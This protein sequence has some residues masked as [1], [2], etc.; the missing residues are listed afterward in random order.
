V[1]PAQNLRVVAF[2]SD[3]PQEWEDSYGNTNLQYDVQVVDE[4]GEIHDA[5][6]SKRASAD[7]PQVNEVVSAKLEDVSGGQFPPKL[8]TV[9]QDGG[10][11]RSGGQRRQSSGGQQRRGAQSSGKGGN[12]GA[13]V[14]M[15]LNAGREHVKAAVEIA[16]ARR[17]AGEQVQVPDFSYQAVVKAAGWYFDVAGHIEKEGE[18]YFAQR[19]QAAQPPPQQ[20]LGAQQPDMSPAP[21]SAE[22]ELAPD[23]TGLG[24]TAAPPADDEIPF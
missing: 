15:A 10:G 22:P 3:E 19:K 14:G 13:R 11:Q 17:A 21:S 1:L 6:W 9:R 7:E 4:Q 24:A 23:T 2:L 8:R 12:M 5:Q 20:Q 18:G 16:L